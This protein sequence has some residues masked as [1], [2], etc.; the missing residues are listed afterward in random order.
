MAVREIYAQMCRI[1]AQ[2][3]NSDA[4][5]EADMLVEFVLGRKRIDVMG[6]EISENDAQRLISCAQRRREGYPLQ[7]MLGRW[8]FFDMELMVGEGVLIPRQDTE[9]VCEAA[10]E[11]INRLPAPTVLD[12]CSGSGCI[13]LAV[14]KYCPHSSVTAVEKS[15]E[16]Y[17]YLCK[18]KE[19]T[20]LQ[21][22]AVQADIFGFEKN[23]SENS[24]DVIISNPPYI[25]NDLRGKLQTEVKHE[26]EMALFAEEDGLLFYRYIAH[27]YRNV[28]K[29]N[30]YLVFE[31]GFDQQAAVKNILTEAG[32]NIIKEIIDLGGNPRGV[33][34]QK[35]ILF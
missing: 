9:T 27:R 8:Y 35:S 21:V 26:P 24:A 2:N 13:A 14:K 4:R 10:F 18:N 12:L 16:A 5:F 6:D 1:M 31:Y 29:E 15:D 23:Q 20:G 28:L 32:Y 7:Y 33:V 17:A 30:G 22:S 19:Y 11:V 34:A 3:P 25:H